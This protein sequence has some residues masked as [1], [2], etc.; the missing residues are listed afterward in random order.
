MPYSVISGFMSGIG[1]ILIILQIAPF[2]GQ[3]NPK[4][5]VLGMVQNLP[6]LLSNINP[7]EATLGILTLAIIFFM[8]AK[9]KRIVPP[10]LVA[11]IVGT[12]VSLTVFGNTDIRRIGEIPVGLP[13]IQMP[14]FTSGQ[15]TVMLID[16][17]MLGILGCIDTLLTA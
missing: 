16:G 13:T 11:L 12:V 9:V 1:V 8:P 7:A 2:V 17:V 14:T 15:V 3:P 4:G 10:Q 5:G 6:Q